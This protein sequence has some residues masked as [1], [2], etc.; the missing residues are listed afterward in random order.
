MEFGQFCPI[1]KAMEVLG[2][3]WTV[4]IL[5]EI[6]MGSSRFNQLQRGLSLISPA[7]LTKRL[8]SLAEYGLIYKT[9]LPGQ[10]GYE[11]LPSPSA[12][13]L[14]PIFLDLGAWGMR[15]TR[16]HLTSLDYDAEFLMLYLQR[17]VKPENLPGR[18]TVIRFNFTDFKEQ[19]SWWIVVSGDQIDVC[20]LDTGREVD[21][22]F[23]S[24]V[25]CLSNIWMG[26]TTYRKE[27]EEGNLKL[28][29]NRA[30]T[31]NVTSW[32]SLCQFAKP[33]S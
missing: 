12:K 6:L 28:V 25:K 13:E 4:L 32:L 19:P 5:R 8:N 30:L 14:L 16:S 2:E 3:K 7:V 27:V 24:T 10:K 29:G 22:Y 9:K 18:T 31:Q 33:D 17:S 26:E 21:V 1:A 11:Y 20:V 15:W 23:T